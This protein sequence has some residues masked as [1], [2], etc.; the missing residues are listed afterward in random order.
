MTS[1]KLINASD[2][3]LGSTNV[4]ALYIGSKKIWERGEVIPTFEINPII[5][6]SNGTLRL[7]YFRNASDATSTGVASFMMTGNS[8]CLFKA[9][10]GIKL[11]DIDVINLPDADGYV[12]SRVLIQR[13][14][15]FALLVCKGNSSTHGTW[16]GG[17]TGSN[18]DI[19]TDFVYKNQTLHLRFRGWTDEDNGVFSDGMYVSKVIKVPACGGSGTEILTFYPYTFYS[20]MYALT[21]LNMYLVDY[22]NNN[23]NNRKD[24]CLWDNEN[25]V[26]RYNDKTVPLNETIFQSLNTSYEYLEGRIEYT[27][28]AN[29][30]NE[31]RDTAVKI[32]DCMIHFVQEPHNDHR[33]Y[34]RRNRRAALD[35][36]YT[37]D[38]SYMFQLFESKILKGSMEFEFEKPGYILFPIDLL[39]EY[40]ILTEGN[41][42]TNGNIYTW[43]NMQFIRYEGGKVS[44]VMAKFIFRKK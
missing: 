35:S 14:D 17:S 6:E 16:S 4:Q 44:G 28:G 27:I 8:T 24:L 1:D 43:D 13:M 15:D 36:K 30:T 2:I 3:K 22:E 7:S 34:V 9:T 21:S 29:N 25:K 39:N 23:T 32:N 11:S 38:D 5:M 40:D 20:Y 42:S 41:M 31:F 12:S 19:Y 18:Y 33:I 26:F 10:P 37:E